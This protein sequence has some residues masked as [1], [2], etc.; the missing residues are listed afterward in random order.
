[1]KT[2]KIIVSIIAGLQ[3]I[4]ICMLLLLTISVCSCSSSKK[5]IQTKYG[6]IHKYQLEEIERVQRYNH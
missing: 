4:F 1:M 5:M 6:F 2:E 3:M